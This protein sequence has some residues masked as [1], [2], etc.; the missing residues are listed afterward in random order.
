M[1]ARANLLNISVVWGDGKW[2]CVG[3]ELGAPKEKG[4]RARNKAKA[5]P[6]SGVGDS[7]KKPEVSHSKGA[8]VTCQDKVRAVGS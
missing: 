2:S 3:R 5:V 8:W 1:C 6:A 7:G 4:R